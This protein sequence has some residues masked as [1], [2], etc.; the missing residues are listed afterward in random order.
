MSTETL[1]I[2]LDA[3]LVKLYKNASAEDKQKIQDLLTVIL[4][5]VSMPQRSLS[6]IMD[7][8]CDEAQANGLTLEI[9]ESILTL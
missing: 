8:M 4:R 3:E 1:S 2:P 6:E 7:E 9:L 5:G